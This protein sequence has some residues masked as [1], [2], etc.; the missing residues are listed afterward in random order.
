MYRAQIIETTL[1]SNS[2]ISTNVSSDVI[3]YTEPKPRAYFDEL[4]SQIS[5]AKDDWNWNSLKLKV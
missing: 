5:D 4:S 3:Y 1:A 2:S